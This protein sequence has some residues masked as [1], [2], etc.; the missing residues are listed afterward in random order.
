MRITGR[1]STPPPK[2]KVPVFVPDLKEG[3]VV[4]A[5]SRKRAYPPPNKSQGENA[6]SGWNFSRTY[7]VRKTRGYYPMQF[8]DLFHMFPSIGGSRR[9]K[10]TTIASSSL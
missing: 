5:L 10:P 3:T 1:V 4:G 6:P 9:S 2:T 7:E 8:W